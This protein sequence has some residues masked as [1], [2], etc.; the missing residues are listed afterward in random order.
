[1]ALR[2]RNRIDESTSVEL[3]VAG[4]GVLVQGSP[5]AVMAY[6]DQINA[7]VSSST[8]KRVLADGLAVAGSVATL[9]S[10]HREYFEFSP[11]AMELLRQHGAIPTKDGFNRSFVRSG[12]AGNS[13]FAGHLDWKPIP[14]GPEQALAAQTMLAALALR[15]AI[16][17]V[18]AA[19]ER[20]EGK[21]DKL[22]TLARAERVGHAVG[23]RRTLQALVDQVRS[24]G[25]ISSTDWST[26][27]SL[28]PL[29]ARD[30]E[31]LRAYAQREI[32]DI[33]DVTFAHQRSAELKELTND[34]IKESL[35]LLIIAEQN[36]V[37][38]QEL[39]IAH[40]ATFE[41]KR[42]NETVD[43]VRARLAALTEA[44]Q[45]LLDSLQQATTK[46]LN[47]SGFEGFNPITRRRLH[48]HGVNLDETMAWF[49]RER[50]LDRSA[51]EIEL[52]TLRESLDNA[53]TAFADGLDTTRTTIRSLASKRSD[54]QPDEPNE[55][56]AET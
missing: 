24:Q 29:I 30:I 8:S 26:V 5:S 54:D 3:V 41:R 21:V 2:K 52:P 33:D 42:L 19:V 34:L 40:V 15:A 28:G 7:L 44:D 38:W 51:L 20:V 31:A 46:L 10:T 47:P 39:R 36:Y 17:D 32:S 53:R 37:L 49:A 11:R 27:A 13:P 6:V 25:C 48:E 45:A 4:T 1:M 43:D 12:T 35:A 55:I 22:V 9:V 50:L 14:L 18:A 23:D 56:Q 16:Q